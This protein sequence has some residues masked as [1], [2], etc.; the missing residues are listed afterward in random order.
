MNI[1]RTS[2]LV[3]VTVLL[4]SAMTLQAQQEPPL[5]LAV[6]YN[7]EHALKAGTEQAFWMEGGSIQLGAFGFRGWGV[8]ADVTGTHSSSI[9]SSGIPVSLVT[10]TFGPRYRWHAEKKLSIYGE[11]L[12][13]EANGFHSLYPSPSGAQSSA[14]GLAL[15][16]GGGVDYKLRKHLALRLLE[17]AWVRTQLPNATNNV[18]NI[19]SLGAGIVARFH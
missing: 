7:A 8:A 11:V 14:N 6:T 19:L 4:G 13:G 2:S 18:Q 3:L 12:A 10:A 5:D 15:Q 16:I 9:G 17:A 1:F